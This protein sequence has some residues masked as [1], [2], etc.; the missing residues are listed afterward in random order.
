M[1]TCR[2]CGYEN[3]RKY[4]FQ[5]HL[6]RKKS[7][8]P[9]L[10]NV[11]I[12]QLKKELLE[13]KRTKNEPKLVQ[14][15]PKLVQNE[16]KLVQEFECNYCEKQFVNK[17]SLNRHL[18]SRCKEKIRIDEEK[19]KEER[20][21]EELRKEIRSMK[22]QHKRELKKQREELK[23][24]MDKQFDKLLARVGD[25]NITTN[26]SNTNNN[27]IILN[28][29]GKEDVSHITTKV[30]EWCSIIPTERVPQLTE[31]IHYHD[32]APPENRNLKI[33]N[34]NK[35]VISVREGGKWKSKEKDDV[36][37]K[38]MNRNIDMMDDLYETTNQ[39]EFSENRFDRFKTD[40][41]RLKKCK[42]RIELSIQDNSV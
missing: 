39:S 24:E 28:D 17:S 19:E 3:S 41:K 15:E 1:Y 12:E 13:P 22:R 2:R 4:N 32:K 6:N 11:S 5:K 29:F 8:E 14:N 21:K 10:E 37:E 40:E 20:E 42:K 31:L 27:N 26:V 30:L 9:I 34:K 18:N 23:A 25:T 36:I 16:P 33:V 35:P 7:C 38:L